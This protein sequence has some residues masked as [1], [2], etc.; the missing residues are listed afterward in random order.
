MSTEDRAEGTAKEW[1]GKA[2]GDRELEVEGR[3]KRTV[4][5]VKQA[6]E[7]VAEGAEDAVDD[8]RDGARGAARAVRDQ[9]RKD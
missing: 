4:G 3:T 8:L 5:R 6:A 1:I 9:S 2:T 7:D